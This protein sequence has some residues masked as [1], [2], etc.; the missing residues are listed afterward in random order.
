MEVPY[1]GKNICDTFDPF[2]IRLKKKTG[3]EAMSSQT[4][5]TDLF[6]GDPKDR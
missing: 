4:V 5:E 2:N 1:P 6:G 3:F